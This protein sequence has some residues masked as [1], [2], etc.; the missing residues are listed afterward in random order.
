MILFRQFDQQEV[1]SELAALDPS[2]GNVVTQGPR[3]SLRSGGGEDLLQI[4]LFC[5]GLRERRL[6]IHDVSGRACKQFVQ[7]GGCRPLR[8][9]NRVC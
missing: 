7:S 9:G 3:H 4:A 5:Y 8:G 2:L 1:R 6:E